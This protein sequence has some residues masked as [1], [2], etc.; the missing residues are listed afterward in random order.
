MVSKRVR[1]NI[2]AI[3]SSVILNCIII[4]AFRENIELVGLVVVPV[5]G[6]IIRSAVA[7]MK[8]IKIIIPAFLSLDILLFVPLWLIILDYSNYAEGIIY[9]LIVGIIMVVSSLITWGIR[10]IILEVS[11]PS[12]A[13][14]QF[15]AQ[16]YYAPAVQQTEEKQ[17]ETKECPKCQTLVN[18]TAR[19]CEECGTS[20]K[21]E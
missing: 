20:F 10:A 19:F 11:K 7:H 5:L 2:I 17:I 12:S 9:G 8:E 14:Q 13:Y 1:N 6:G 3:S 18:A 21:I 15:Y 16:A 4:G